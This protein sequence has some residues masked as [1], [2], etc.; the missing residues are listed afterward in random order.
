MVIL[1]SLL[2]YSRRCLFVCGFAVYRAAEK[3]KHIYGRRILNK[4]FGKKLTIAAKANYI[5]NIGNFVNWMKRFW[6]KGTELNEIYYFLCVYS[7]II[8]K[9]YNNLL[10]KCFSATR[11]DYLF[12]LNNRKDTAHILTYTFHH[13]RYTALRSTSM[14]S[15]LIS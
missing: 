13:Y 11:I 6:I 9:R 1:F 4:S 14:R 10:T 8:T 15:E 7:T 12:I 2:Y 5:L 3:W